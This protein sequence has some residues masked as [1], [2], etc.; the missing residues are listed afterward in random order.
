MMLSK[1]QEELAVKAV[2]AGL[3]VVRPESREGIPQMHGIVVRASPKSAKLDPLR[4]AGVVLSPVNEGVLLGA[5]RSEWAL[6]VYVPAPDHAA[7][8]G[9]A[10]GSGIVGIPRNDDPD[11][12]LI[13]YEGALYKQSEMK[14]LADR[15]FHALGRLLEKAPTIAMM[16]APGDSLI[17][18]GIFE[19]RRGQVVLVP[20]AEEA[21]KDWLGADHLDPAELWR[22]GQIP[23]SV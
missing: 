21:V 2:A 23:E 8:A 6:T 7:T 17:R 15:V 14:Y 13:Y 22:A 19:P 3:E 9:I 10:R 12:V 4:D 20:D 5:P 16:A 11:S 18:V 1:G